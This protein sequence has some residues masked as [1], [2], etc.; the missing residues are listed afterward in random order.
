[1]GHAGV[2]D[3]EELV[4]GFLLIKHDAVRDVD[5]LNDRLGFELAKFNLH[6][7]ILLTVFFY[8]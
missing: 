8:Y 2:D 6:V 1:M 7:S 4:L 5:D 3:V